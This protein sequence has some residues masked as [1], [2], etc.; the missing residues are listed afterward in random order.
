MPSGCM[1]EDRVAGKY[2][3]SQT[4]AAGYPT[5]NTKNSMGSMGLWPLIFACKF[6]ESYFYLT[7]LFSDPIWV[8]VRMKIQGCTL[9]NQAAFTLT[10]MYIIDLM[11]FF[12]DT[13]LWY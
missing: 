1:V 12:L 13:L 3:V 2:L 11:L 5:L 8:M 10:I 9:H 7:L 4:F 6:M